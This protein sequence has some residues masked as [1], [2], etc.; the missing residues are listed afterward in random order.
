M[1]RDTKFADRGKRSQSGL[2]FGSRAPRMVCDTID[3]TKRA[4]S[5]GSL[6][7]PSQLLTPVGGDSPDGSDS[8]G[9]GSGAARRAVSACSLT[10]KGAPATSADKSGTRMTWLLVYFSFFLYHYHYPPFFY[11][12]PL[13]VL[14][15][16]FPYFL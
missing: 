4:A 15:R 13:S 7:R 8:G 10:R 1:E 3:S 16:R 5:Q 12:Y 2:G 6:L 9:G 11:S 14:F